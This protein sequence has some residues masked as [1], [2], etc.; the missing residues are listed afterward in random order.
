MS[1]GDSYTISSTVLISVDV[2]IMGELI[3]SGYR[4]FC[5]QLTYARNVLYQLI[6]IA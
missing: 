4:N 3:M 5:T 6:V 2:Q 1:S